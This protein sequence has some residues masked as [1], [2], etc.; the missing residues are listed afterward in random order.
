MYSED[1]YKELVYSEDILKMMAND[2]PIVP[3]F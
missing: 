2:G 1:S 3:V